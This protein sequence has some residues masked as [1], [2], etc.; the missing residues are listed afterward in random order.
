MDRAALESLRGGRTAC[1][2]P[3]GRLIRWAGLDRHR[4]TYASRRD[5]SQEAPQSVRAALAHA[6][7]TPSGRLTLAGMAGAAL[8][9]ITIAY[10]LVNL[11]LWPFGVAIGG[12]INFVAALIGMLGVQLL[13]LGG[14]GVFLIKSVARAVE[15]AQVLTPYVVSGRS[16]FADPLESPEEPC[17]PDE[18]ADEPIAGGINL[19]T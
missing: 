5:A 13:L 8:L 9:A 12:N 15:N 1:P 11:L 7:R 4:L 16:G 18:Q 17:E 2:A 10:G 19:F 3:L 6:V 14:G